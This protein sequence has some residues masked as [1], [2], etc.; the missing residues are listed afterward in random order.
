V[1]WELMSAE[2]LRPG[3]SVDMLVRVTNS[4]SDVLRDARMT[5]TLPPE[6]SIERAVDARRDRDGLIFADIPAESTHES[7]VTLRLHRAVGANRTLA[8]EAWLHGRGVSPVQF[9]PLDVP[10]YAQ[11]Q[12]AQS[13]QVLAIPSE[14]VN[15]GERLYYEVRLR[16]EGDGPAD[17][18]N[19]RVVPTNLA[20]Y[21]PSSTTING[22]TIADDAGASQLWSARGLALA[23]VHPTVE[24][25][26]RWEMMVMSPLAAGTALDTRA[27]IEYG[28]GT[29][30]AISAPTVRVQAQ[31]S[32]S[33]STAG[34]PI[35][36]AR[37]FGAPQAEPTPAPPVAEEVPFRP[38]VSTSSAASAP[39]EQPPRALTEIVESFAATPVAPAAQTASSSAQEHTSPVLYVDFT[40]DR[41]NNTLRM[42]ER[43]DS[44]GGLLQH[45]FALRLLFPEHVQDAPANV[46][47]AF[48]NGIRALR[49]PLEKLFVRLRMPR[50]T[51]AGKDLEDRESREA[52]QDLIE[53]LSFARTA[54][55]R[56]PED[57]R[58]VRISG[59]VEFDVLRALLRDLDAAPIGA[60]KPWMINGQMLGST[61]YHG[62]ERSDVLEQYRS[63][64]LR[65]LS[66]LDELPIEEFHR[67]LTSS[68]NRALD[69]GLVQVTQALRGAAPIALE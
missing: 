18:L 34:T 46:D 17:R 61:I 44:A 54:A 41:L 35:S 25:R 22:V 36:I 64:L 27:I 45:L 13:A 55:P 52:M 69:E 43:S 32:L 11:P 19:I 48:G 60:A 16:N 1:E 47:D 42:I 65:V 67:V 12:F 8:L 30:F 21:V 23:D 49:A 62:S 66:V 57:E 2:A 9:A 28:D 3:R 4:G 58:I 6:L 56:P 59:A 26:L 7:R 20:V 39:L 51:I 10:T 31:P 37:M 33:E 24:L 63:E 38:Q 68:V 14:S 5:L 50:L 53:S 29:S 15:S 40:P